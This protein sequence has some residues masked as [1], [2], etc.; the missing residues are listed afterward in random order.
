MAKVHLLLWLSL[1]MPRES[2]GLRLPH[3]SMQVVKQPALEALRQPALKAFKLGSTAALAINVANS[4]AVAAA[5]QATVPFSLLGMTSFELFPIQ[6]L[7]LLTWVLLLFL[8]RWKLTPK[9]ALISPIVHSM[10]YS[11]LLVHL[12]KFPAPGLSVDFTSLKGVMGGFS[13]PDGVFAGSDCLRSTANCPLGT[14]TDLSSDLQ[15]SQSR[16]GRLATLLRLR[17]TRCSRHRP[18]C[19]TQSRASRALRSQSH[20]DRSRGP[21]GLPV[22]HHREDPLPRPANP[23]F[24]ET[25]GRLCMG[26]DVLS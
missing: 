4:P 23:E 1:V 9:L 3:I 20:L 14:A 19:S 15:C 2:L 10:L 21:Y 12:V 6:N 11:K 25:A 18:R 22:L 26:K 24:H 5:K 16:A 17:S 7:S 13:I 8:P